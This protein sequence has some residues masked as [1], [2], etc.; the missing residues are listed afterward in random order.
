ME[1][2]EIEELVED[3]LMDLRGVA[4]TP[5]YTTTFE[6]DGSVGYE[7]TPFCEKLEYQLNKTLKRKL[8]DS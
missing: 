5:L 1:K 4:I 2:V 6:E 3:I 8:N 7:K